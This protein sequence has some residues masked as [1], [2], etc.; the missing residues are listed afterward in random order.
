MLQQKEVDFEKHRMQL[1]AERDILKESNKVLELQLSKYREDLSMLSKDGLAAEVSSEQFQKVQM[2]EVGLKKRIREMEVQMQQRTAQFGE[3]EKVKSKMVDELQSQMVALKRENDS[4]EQQLQN[5]Q[6]LRNAQAKSELQ[7]QLQTTQVALESALSKA[8]T[9]EMRL[10][11]QE[12][13]RKTI[14][15]TTLDLLKETQRESSKMA[16]THTQKS[17]DLLRQEWK[18]EHDLILE[19][20]S[21]EYKHQIQKFQQQLQTD[22]LDQLKKQMYLLQVDYD[23]LKK[24]HQDC[25]ERLEML[26][27]GASPSTAE[28]D[29][30]SL[31]IKQLE[32][33][34]SQSEIAKELTV[35]KRER[36]DLKSSLKA[37]DGRIREF[38]R[39]VQS[40]LDGILAMKQEIQYL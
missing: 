26:K 9:L 23:N 39:E 12:T 5:S 36:D 27:N 7:I 15:Q 13:A 38:E 19:Q 31:K 10:E 40:L 14:Q 30:L 4:L 22:G 35:I 8:S 34:Q 29:R 25:L 18:R 17:I 33:R 24:E 21:K 2:Q 20:K 16:F 37:R 1:Q 32:S 6:S 11:M 28:F 3:W